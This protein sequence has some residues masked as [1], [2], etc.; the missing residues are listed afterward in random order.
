MKFRSGALSCPLSPLGLACNN[1]VSNYNYPVMPVCIKVESFLYLE[2]AIFVYEN[3]RTS[4][5]KSAL[6]ILI[7]KYLS[8]CVERE[9]LIILA[10][11]CLPLPSLKEILSSTL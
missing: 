4:T 8:L 2:L 6:L 10:V 7:P 11:T 1:D 5:V 3:L 9:I